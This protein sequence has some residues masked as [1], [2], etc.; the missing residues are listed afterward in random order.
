[1]KSVQ[2]VEE[3]AASLTQATALLR[4]EVRKAIQR[5]EQARSL[6]S[7][8]ALAELDRLSNLSSG[9]KNLLRS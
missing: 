4:D 1:M 3:A 7:N 9:E 2:T 5:E 8:Q 6:S